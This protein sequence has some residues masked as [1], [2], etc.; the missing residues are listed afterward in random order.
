[1]TNNSS[2]KKLDILTIR[3]RLYEADGKLKHFLEKLGL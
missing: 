3:D 2:T 1:M